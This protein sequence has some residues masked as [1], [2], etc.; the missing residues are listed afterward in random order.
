M[1]QSKEPEEYYAVHIPS[2][3]DGISAEG[4]VFT[5]LR[6]ASSFANIPES[7]AKGARFKR[8]RSPD[9]A[10]HYAENGDIFCRSP[11]ISNKNQA[12]PE[13]SSI[14]PSISRIMLNRL[15]KAI[16]FKDDKLFLKMAMQN[17]RYLINIG[18]DTPTIVVEGFRYNAMHL[19]AKFGNLYV[20]RHILHLVCD[21]QTLF[22]LYGTSEEDVKMRSHILLDCYLNMPDKGANDTPLHFASKFGH[23]H[24]VELF[25]SYSVCQKNSINKIGLTPAQV[26][27]TRYTGHDKKDLRAIMMPLFVSFFVALYRPTDNYYSA[28]LQLL[29]QVPDNTLPNYAPGSPSCISIFEICELAAYA[30]PF[31]DKAVAQEFYEI[32][33]VEERDCRRSCP[34]KGAERIG[35]LLA[36]EY[37][38]TWM[39]RWSF[40]NKLINFQS[41]SGLEELNRHLVY[42]RLHPPT[43]DVRALTFDDDDT[44]FFADAS[45]FM[46]ME[47][48][49]NE[50]VLN[51]RL[52][53]LHLNASSEDDGLSMENRL[54]SESLLDSD[55]YV[56]V[57]DEQ[58]NSSDKSSCSVDFEYHT[59][60]SS[61]EPVY[62]Y[63]GIPSKDD[64]ELAAAL[65]LVDP[66]LIQRFGAI[67][68]YVRHVRNVPETER[69]QWPFTDSPRAKRR[70]M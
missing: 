33:K 31:A 58:T 29:D 55:S 41:F 51:F 15:K 10:K 65:S 64:E 48:Q 27:C 23:R 19:A 17:P 34:R 32:W 6:E 9:D 61:P 5:T 37:K 30:G 47:E 70:R 24:L 54:T 36:S 38:V 12:A 25:V 52:T 22:A 43:S 59:P 8:F 2:P 50:N 68:E 3:C 16:E 14:F 21:S 18:S 42:I 56:V 44:S 1:E 60:P 13:P 57:E 40:C 28:T 39:E 46:F 45:D 49:K 62:I 63:E 11:E 4:A 67:A 35:R 53:N 20:A 26:C 7:K 69:S 66:Q